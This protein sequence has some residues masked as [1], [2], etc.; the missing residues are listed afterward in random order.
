MKLRTCA[1]FVY[2]TLRMKAS[3][4]YR[5]PFTVNLGLLLGCPFACRYCWQDHGSSESLPLDVV[6]AI[7]RD[8]RQVG[9]QRVHLT[10]GEPMLRDDLL[11]IV[12]CAKELGFF[13]SLTTNGSRVDRQIDALKKVDQVQLSFD[14]PEETRALLCGD[15]A[16]KVASQ[17]VEFF[18]ENDIPFWTATVL[19]TANLQRIDWI[20]DHARRHRTQA[21][22]VL[23]ERHPEHWNESNPMPDHVRELLPTAEENQAVLRRL[24]ALKK[25]GAPIGS[26]MPYLQELLEWEDHEGLISPRESRRYRCMAWQSQCEVFANGELHVCEWTLREGLGVSVLE[27]GFKG[28][29]ERLPKPA[30]CNSCIASCYLESNLM[31]SLNL[32]SIANWAMRLR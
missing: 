31:F 3:S 22:F 17:A 30:D 25:E 16:A 7:L 15:H 13:V 20:V 4:R 1:S 23:M 11:E 27:H 8:A 18:E 14:G 10:G 21:N 29:W 26:S 28:A 32:R 6:T 9:G 12:N 24:I 5:V 19:T 2:R